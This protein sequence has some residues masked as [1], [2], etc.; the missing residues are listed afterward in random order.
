[1]VP[2]IAYS[3]SDLY[4]FFLENCS[5]FEFSSFYLLYDGN[6][7]FPIACNLINLSKKNSFSI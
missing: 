5:F 4:D 1:M 2:L 3:V 6:S 7:L